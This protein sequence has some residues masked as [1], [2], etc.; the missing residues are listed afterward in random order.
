MALPRGQLDLPPRGRIAS[1]A[2]LI[3]ASRSGKFHFDFIVELFVSK[4]G[5]QQGPYSREQLQSLV[6][7]GVFASEDLCWHQGL[8][9]W[10]T[11]SSIV[12]ETRI[13]NDPAQTTPAPKTESLS[14]WSLVLGIFSWFCLSILAGIPAI[15]CGHISLGRIAK[16]PLLRG[17]G[18]S[19]AGLILGYTS[20]LVIPVVAVLAALALPAVTGALERGKA[21][22]SLNNARQIGIAMQSAAL[23][24]QI[25]GKQGVGWPADIGL[26]SVPAIRQ[27]LVTNNY[28]T[29][30]DAE[31]LG[32]ENFLIGNVSEN[33]P[34]GTILVKSKPVSGKFS[35]VLLKDGQGN[36]YRP[37][38]TEEGEIPPRDPPFL[39]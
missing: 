7:S 22:Q 26:G 21:M 9:G 24:A 2:V 30:G 35:V 39:E 16:N 37:G 4:N 23:D 34:A 5:G 20:V 15:V 3:L 31:K 29:E 33:D 11:I 18:M 19:I 25:A 8:S 14:I 6:Q 12:G 17:K 27:M 28:L 1:V 13:Q 10:Q 32:F 36:V 38:K